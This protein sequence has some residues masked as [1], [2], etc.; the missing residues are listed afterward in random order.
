M[1]QKREYK[2]NHKS[3]RLCLLPLVSASREL[4]RRSRGAARWGAGDA[5]A[6][7]SDLSLLRANAN[8]LGI[9]G[10]QQVLQLEQK[11]APEGAVS[12]QVNK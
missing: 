8:A 11:K 6:D 7:V 1:P 5:G 4:R 10:R 2:S 9:L 3:R 12:F